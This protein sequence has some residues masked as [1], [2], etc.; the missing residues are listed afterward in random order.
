MTTSS[1]ADAVC[2]VTPYDVTYDGSAHT[3][4]GTATGVN[5]EPLSGL[6]LSGTTHTN[7]GFYKDD[8]WTFTDVTGNYNNTE[9]QGRRQH[10]QGRCGLHGH[11]LRCDLRW[12]TPTPPP[13]QATGVKGEP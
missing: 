6:D 7:A 11:A 4:T 12:Q 9:R 10:R 3:A 13:A 8:P 2:T 1:K 5:G